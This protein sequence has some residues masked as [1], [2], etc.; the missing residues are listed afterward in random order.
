MALLKKKRGP[1]N[2]PDQRPWK[3]LSSWNKLKRGDTVA[4]RWPDHWKIAMHWEPLRRG[5]LLCTLENDTIIEV[6]SIR[7]IMVLP[8]SIDK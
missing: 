1:A 7:Q 2:P 5:G 6:E 4:I 3:N 8:A